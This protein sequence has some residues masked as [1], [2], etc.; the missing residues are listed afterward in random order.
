M[1]APTISPQAT[2]SLASVDYELLHCRMGHP[3][4]D[5]L[6]AARKHIQDLSDVKIPMQDPI[7]PGCQLGKQPNRPFP[8]T[9][10]RA[11]TPFEL[12]HSDLNHLRWN[13][14]ISTNMPS[15][16]TLHQWHGL[17]VCD[18]KIRP[19]RPQNSTY[20]M[21]EHNTTPLLRAGDLM[22]AAS[23]RQRHSEIISKTMEYT[24]ISPHPMLTSR[25]VAQNG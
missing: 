5:V 7:C 3:S 25:M 18:R 11:T 10:R 1:R 24:S 20:P 13:R 12:I 21:S 15:S 23:S 19:S 8:H 4:K 16:T 2:H 17:Y 22:L 14:I 9:E 6:R